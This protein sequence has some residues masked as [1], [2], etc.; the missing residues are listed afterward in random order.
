MVCTCAGTVLPEITTHVPRGPAGWLLL[1]IRSP[2]AEPSMNPLSPSRMSAAERLDEIADLLAAGVIRLSDGKSSQISA[3][4]GESSL[5]FSP[6]QSGHA[7]VQN[8]VGDA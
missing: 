4:R 3:D 7:V 8:L 6:R 1:G 5:D 2:K